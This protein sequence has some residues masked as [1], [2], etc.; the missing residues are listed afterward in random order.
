[1]IIPHPQVGHIVAG[2]ERYSSGALIIKAFLKLLFLSQDMLPYCLERL[3]IADEY[4]LWRALTIDHL[5]A[6][7]VKSLSL[8][9][10]DGVR[11]QLDHLKFN[12]M[13]HLGDIYFS[14]SLDQMQKL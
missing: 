5:P 1:M 8:W 11:T 4:S 14:D 9:E 2:P 10:E 12:Q 7:C 6:P 13:E 3:W